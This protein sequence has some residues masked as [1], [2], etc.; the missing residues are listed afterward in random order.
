MGCLRRVV[1]RAALADTRSRTP[2]PRERALPMGEGGTHWRGMRTVATEGYG[3]LAGQLHGLD[4]LYSGVCASLGHGACRDV[5]L[6]AWDRT[7][8]EGGVESACGCGG[9]VQGEQGVFCR[10]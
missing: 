5:L 2:W 3:M 8:S 1:E 4:G 9:E 7:G 6:C 10:A